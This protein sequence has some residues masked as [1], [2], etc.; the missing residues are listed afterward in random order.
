MTRDKA[1]KYAKYR[2]P[3]ST[4]ASEFVIQ[5]AIVGQGVVADIGAGSGILTQH[6]V[7]KV[8]KV[9][10]VEPE[11]EMLR[12][13]QE[14]LGER[15]DIEYI[16]GVAE[17]TKLL[18]KSVDLIVAANAYHRFPPESTIEEFKRILKPGGM[19]AIFSYQDDFN[20]IRDTMHVSNIEQYIQRLT[21]TRHSEPVEYFYGDSAPSRFL[22]KQ[23]HQE[24]W[25][26]YWGAVISSMESPDEREDWFVAFQDAHKQR[27]NDI[28][29]DGVISIKYSTEVWLGQPKYK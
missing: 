25:N 22:F 2:L 12:I 7:G 10:A 23:E 15:Q 9:F 27:F 14:L 28:A 29:K 4:E 20:F 13:A 16:A 6:F 5:T 19:L 11:L 26:E 21:A 8:R 17:D 3:Y 1:L 18:D 24:G